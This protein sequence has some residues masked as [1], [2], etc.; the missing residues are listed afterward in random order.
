MLLAFVVPNFQGLHSNFDDIVIAVG[1]GGT[2]C[3]LA[4]AN[5]LTGSKVRLGLVRGHRSCQLQVRIG[6]GSSDPI[7]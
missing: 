6:K 7:A 2:L 1:S 4:V 5:Y 3:G